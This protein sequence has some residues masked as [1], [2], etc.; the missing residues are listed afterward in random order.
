MTQNTPFLTFPENWTTGLAIVAHPDDLEYGA[1]SAIA[2]WTHQG[3]NISYLLLTKGE[4]GIETLS[5]EETV[6]LRVEEEIR[7]AAEVGVT[8][9]E[10]LD[11]S[12]GVIEYGLQLRKDLARAIRRHRPET[13]LSINYR[14]NWG[15]P[16]TWNMADHRN[17]GLALLDAARDAANRWIF[18][19]LQEKEQLAPWKPR[20]VAFSGSPQ[21]THAVDVSEWIEKGVASLQHHKAYL[22]N[23]ED[24]PDPDFFLRSLAADAGTHFGCEYAVKFEVFT[25]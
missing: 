25:P 8:H 9:V 1:A 19:E 18:P 10:F 24:H 20:I 22:D 16:G 23:L 3:K 6:R 21:S 2:R 5:P 13:I 7:S 12:D 17:T 4:A 11:Y 14:E 15:L